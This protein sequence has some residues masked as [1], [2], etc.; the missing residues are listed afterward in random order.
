MSGDEQHM[1]T[2]WEDPA[3]KG[4]PCFERPMTPNEARE[5]IERWGMRLALLE[6]VE[7]A[8]YDLAFAA[9][10]LVI[11]TDSMAAVRRQREVVV[12]GLKEYEA[13]RAAL[14]EGTRHD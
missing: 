6:K 11:A 3:G 1:P 7:E 14:V 4:Y 2:I 5:T 10:N 8:A 9:G 12:A 13:A